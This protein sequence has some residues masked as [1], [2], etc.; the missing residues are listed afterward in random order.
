MFAKD[1]DGV[2]GVFLTILIIIGVLILALLL[3]LVIAISSASNDS[4]GGT[5]DSGGS[6][7][8][9]SDSGGSSCYVATMTY[10]SYDAPE[11]LVLRKFRDRFLKKFGLGRAFI[12]WY[13]ANSPAFVEKH[14]SKSWMHKFLRVYLNGLVRIVKPFLR[15]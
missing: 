13:Y 6:D 9:G 10:G 11:V 7:S 12:R 1:D 15:K 14:K 4:G 5:S 2:A 8:G 3:V